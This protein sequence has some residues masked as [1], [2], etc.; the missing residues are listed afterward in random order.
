MTSRA[1][2][3]AT[4]AMD[5]ESVRMYVVRPMLSPST[6]MPSYSRW[7][8]DIVRR[9]LKPSLRLAS[10]W[11]VL[12]VNGAAGERFCCAH[13]DLGHLGRAPRRA[14]ACVSAVS[15]SETVEGLA[16]DA[17]QVGRERLARQSV[18][19]CACSVQYSRAVKAVTSRSR[20]TTSR[21]ATDWT[22]PAD[23]PLRTL[24]ASNGLSV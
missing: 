15:P 22:R 3:I 2:P 8:T 14:S 18:W 23:R 20:S 13:R 7:A 4:P 21:T 16:V 12:V 6:S 5:I 10:C 11:R 19:S 17:H 24:R 9:G 1:S